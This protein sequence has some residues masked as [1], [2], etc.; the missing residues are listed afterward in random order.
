MRRA[1]A[2]YLAADAEEMDLRLVPLGPIR[3][4]EQ[5]VSVEDFR[6]AADWAVQAGLAQLAM[7]LYVPLS[8]YWIY[9]GRLAEAAHWL[10]R[11][12]QLDV[13][14]SLMLWRLQLAAA[15]L[16]FYAGRNEQAEA[17]FR[18][19]S[20]SALQMGEPVVSADALQFVGR[21]RWRRGDLR[22]G[23][24][25]MA[26]AVE[27]QSDRVGRA[28]LYGNAREGL[29]VLELLL[30][31]IAAA[32]NQADLLAVFADGND[33]P[34]ATCCALNVRGWL[35]CYRGNLLESI[36]CFQ[37]CRD[38]AIEV[39]DWDHD[40]NARLGLAWVFPALGLPDQALA[41]AKAAHDLS[42][43][44]GNRSKQA[45]SMIVMGGAQLDLGDLPRAALSMAEGLKI[46]RDH[47]RRVDY[48]SRGLRF[49][50]WIAQ[51]NGHSARALRFLT[52]A[53]AEH[54]RIHFV[55]PPADAVRA[56]DTLAVAS[57]ALSH[58]EGRAISKLA[59]RAPL[60]E[61]VDEAVDYLQETA[62]DHP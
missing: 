3:R 30:G 14:E 12:S 28:K 26:T 27:A 41:Q 33:D 46:L 58:A 22:G 44:P 8:H 17:A 16:D 7:D 10:G 20:A 23:R 19:L 29:A 24:D 31:N 56:A 59:E 53:E 55:D 38:I 11:V 57:G 39:G 6:A 48:M 40:V 47:T 9:S 32:Q 37:Q 15:I 45:E 51:A 62:A 4:I 43:D 61:V 18:S 42:L 52:A 25:D 21:V 5:N 1:H 13:E 2:E 36:R 34:Y 50:G 35:A 54:H 60:A 49:A